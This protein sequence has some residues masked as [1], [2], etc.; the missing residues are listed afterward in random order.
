MKKII[1]LMLALLWLL[2]AVAVCEEAPEAEAFDDPGASMAST[3]ELTNMTI[4]VIQNGRAKGVR[5]KN[6]TL[7]LSIGSAEGVPTMQVN[8]DNGKGQQVDVV[9]QIVESYLDLEVP[10]SG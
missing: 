2:A 5:L 3:L 6:M 9:M 1:A 4:S 10:G 7:C 8:F